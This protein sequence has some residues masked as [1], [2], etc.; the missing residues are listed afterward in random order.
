MAQWDGLPE[1]GLHG[2]LYIGLA[3]WRVCEVAPRFVTGWAG[4]GPKASEG[5]D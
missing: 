4:R 1:I 3:L 5:L 2:G